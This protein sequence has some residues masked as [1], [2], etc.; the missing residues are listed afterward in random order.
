MKYNIVETD[1]H[2]HLADYNFRIDNNTTT[3]VYYMT[4]RCNFKCEFCT[5]WHKGENDCLTDKYSVGQIEDHFNDLSQRIGKS[6]YIWL[7]G[8]EPSV[9]TNFTELSVALTKN[10]KIE[11]QTNLTTKNI[12][13]FANSV[14]PSRVGEVM[15]TYHPDTLC[16]NADLEELYF[17]NFDYLTSRGFSVVFKTVA[18]PGVLDEFVNKKIPYY[19]S[20]LPRNTKMLIQ[21]FIAVIKGDGGK[22]R[23]YP[24]D[25]TEHEKE[26]LGK[27]LSY[28]RNETLDYIAGAKSFC[29]MR[30]DAGNGFIAINKTGRA[31]RCVADMVQDKNSMGELMKNNIVLM[32]NYQKCTRSRCG[33]PY[34]AL[35]YGMNAWKYCGDAGEKMRD[36][37]KIKYCRKYQ[38]LRGGVTELIDKLFVKQSK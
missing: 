36:Y 28:R 38:G 20:R 30:C 29:G 4:E 32:K 31:Y 11:L 3:V 12:K 16:K 22:I 5:G 37:A 6:L 18:F 25:Y 15:A 13:K 27:I 33:A 24:Y 2:N 26:I 8:G 21:P 17:T 9:A 35:W 23:E 34:W 10:H 7:T 1:S 19:Q 14:D